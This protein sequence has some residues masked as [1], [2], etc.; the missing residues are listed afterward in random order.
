MISY[1]AFVDELEKI[2]FGPSDANK[3][4]RAAKKHLTSK[5]FSK[6]IG[7]G[8]LGAFPH[9]RA[10][11]QNAKYVGRAIQNH[12]SPHGVLEKAQLA[13]LKEEVDRVLKENPKRTPWSRYVDSAG[14]RI[15]RVSINKDGPKSLIQKGYNVPVLNP[16]QMKM[17]NAVRIGHELDE[18]KVRPSHVSMFD[19]HLSPDVIFREH[20]RVVTLPKGYEGVGV[21][22]KAIRGPENR[23][24][25]R[26][27][28][29]EYGKGQRLSRHA[30]KRMVESLER[31]A[32]KD[33]NVLEN[34][35]EFLGD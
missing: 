6:R 9:S 24:Y 2:A 31:K 10:D 16:S 29:L 15:E 12:P 32:M 34:L 20:N 35:G 33:P 25:F 22:R 5:A 23:S 26:P 30:R 13:A 27:F 3:V 7:S 8:S 14:G 4:F 17:Y 19:N 1:D 21:A 18:L 28:G 11:V